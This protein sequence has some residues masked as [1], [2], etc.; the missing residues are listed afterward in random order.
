MNWSCGEHADLKTANPERRA[1]TIKLS[2]NKLL[3]MT[4]SQSRVT[5][6]TQQLERHMI[7]VP[8]N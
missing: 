7:Y 8:K 3:E 5:Y 4:D 6:I 2:L 1:Q